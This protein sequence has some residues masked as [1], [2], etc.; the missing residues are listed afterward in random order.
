MV[1][2]SE[3]IFVA[4]AAA[5]VETQ[6]SITATKQWANVERVLNPAG[7]TAGFTVFPVPLASVRVTW[8]QLWGSS[9]YPQLFC[10]AHWPSYLNCSQEPATHQTSVRRLELGAAINPRLGDRWRLSLGVGGGWTGVLAS[11]SGL[12]SGRPE[13]GI[14]TAFSLGTAVWV[15]ADRQLDQSG[16]FGASIEVHRILGETLNGCAT[17]V[18]TPFCH[19]L[20]ATSVHVGFRIRQVPEAGHR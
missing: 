1:V 13:A 4:P 9:E 8:T 12:T 6:L 17:D 11:G 15:G 2:G 5:Q 7:V 10:D 19:T 18:A 20:R 3:L 16:R 14:L